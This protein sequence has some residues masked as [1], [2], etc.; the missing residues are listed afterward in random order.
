MCGPAPH[1]LAPGGAACAKPVPRP[2]T[3]LAIKRVVAGPGDQIYLSAGHI[4]RRATGSS[5]FVRQADAY[6][7]AC[8]G[9]PMCSFPTPIEVP[10]DHWYVLGDNRGESSDSRF[11]G[12]IP[13]SWIVGIGTGC[14]TPRGPVKATVPAGFGECRLNARGE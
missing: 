6:T 12:A 5:G 7:R 11:W 3:V 2:S 13:T 8:G 14:A 9:A 10:A 1:A 4:Y